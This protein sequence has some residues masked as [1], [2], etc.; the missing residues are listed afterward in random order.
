VF[1]GV[2]V[3]YAGFNAE[4]QIAGTGTLGAA[5]SVNFASGA[6]QYGTL[7]DDTVLALLIP[8]QGEPA[9]PIP[10]RYQL[11]LTHGA[12]GPF[13]PSF[14]GPGAVHLA[15]DTEYSPEPGD[16]DI[17]TFF[18]DGDGDAWAAVLGFDAPA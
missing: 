2:T 13:T 1:E 5:A 18:V 11:R 7:D 12:S 17:V 8:E 4:I 10:G 9:A 16:V 14:T 3:D 6:A 15:R